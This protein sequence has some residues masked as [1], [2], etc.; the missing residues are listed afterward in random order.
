MIRSQSLIPKLPAEIEE[1]MYE[2]RKNNNLA[3]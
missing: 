3:F 1:D 2:K